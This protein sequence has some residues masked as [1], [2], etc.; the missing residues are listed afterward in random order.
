MFES[1][2]NV[3]QGTDQ[4]T[5]VATTFAAALLFGGLGGTA[6]WLLGQKTEIVRE[7]EVEVTFVPRAAPAPVEEPEPPPKAAPPPPAPVIASTPSPAAA[8]PAAARPTGPVSTRRAF[9][10][11]T[12][13]PTAA[14]MPVDPVRAD[15]VTAVAPA[16][17]PDPAPQPT[18]A[19]T[20]KP[21][22]TD[23]RDGETPERVTG[24]VAVPE[25]FESPLAHE[26]NQRPVYPKNA[27][28]DGREGEVV[29]ELRVQVDGTVAGTKV[30]R[31][32]EPFASAA[33]EA[34]KTW[35]Y[36]PARVSGS[37]IEVAR[38]VRLPFKVRG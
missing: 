16:P 26:G 21:E 17:P 23:T 18:P 36:E 33:L 11:P 30:V 20:A 7:S 29:I 32:E 28:R 13:A 15:P 12:R 8:A 5:W 27:L 24:P 22:I 14:P 34:V 19:V 3:S 6:L 35:R 9:Q 37:P 31:G 2:E 38:R 10:A 25:A 4:K 1:L